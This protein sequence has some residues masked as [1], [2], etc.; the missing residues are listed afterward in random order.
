MRKV[1]QSKLT[2]LTASAKTA[3][4]RAVL[5]TVEALITPGQD[6]AAREFLERMPTAEQLMP[7]LE[8]SD[9]GLKTWTPPDSAAEEL[10]TPMTTADRK[11]A[12]V[13]QAIKAN[14]DASDREVARIAGVDHKTVAGV[15]RA[16]WHRWGTS[17][18][19]RWEIPSDGES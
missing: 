7:P 9:L 14:P 4:D 15:R 6:D 5:E 18:R 13:R 19:L 1:A 16:Y 11:R 10:L 8:L 3:I 17:A 12:K 2:A